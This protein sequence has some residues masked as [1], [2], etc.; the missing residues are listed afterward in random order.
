MK[1]HRKADPE[2]GTVLTR[3]PVALPTCAQSQWQC[4]YELLI[5]LSAT[6]VCA[7][8]YVSSFAVEPGP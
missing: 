7:W 5:I 3:F 4:E 8:L 2:T 6:N 1:Q